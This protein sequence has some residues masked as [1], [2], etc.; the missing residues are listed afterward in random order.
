MDL[1]TV[2][3]ENGVVKEKWTTESVTYYDENGQLYPTA[4]GGEQ[5]NP[6]PLTPEELGIFEADLISTLIEVNLAQLKDPSA[7][8]AVIAEMNARIGSGTYVATGIQDAK[9][10]LTSLSLMSNNA[11]AADF[12]ANIGRWLKLFLRN[13]KRI[14]NQTIRLLRIVGERLDSASVGD[15]T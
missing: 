11:L 6:R 9:A 4:P 7:I 10:T 1:R 3:Y 12:Q 15:E 2:F 14:A 8:D 5:P 13:D